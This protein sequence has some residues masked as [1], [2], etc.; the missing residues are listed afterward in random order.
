MLVVGAP[1]YSLLE[2]HWP[3]REPKTVGVLV[4]DPKSGDSALRLVED[5]SGLV[6]DED[7]E[8]V[9]ALEADLRREV[10]DK[11][12]EAVLEE[13]E[14]SLSNVL[15]LGARAAARSGPLEHTL[16]RLFYRHAEPSL[17]V[18]SLRAAAGGFGR[19][20]DVETEGWAPA[21][22]HLAARDDLFVAHV[23]GDS[24]EPDIPS[25]SLCVFRK[26]GGGTRQGKILLVEM[27]GTS[28]GGGAVTIKRYRSRKSQSDEGW[29]HEQIIMEPLNPKYEPWLLDPDES[30]RVIGE[31]VQVL[32][33]QP[34]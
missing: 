32:R 16:E 33:Q 27:E 31:F 12:G 20:E 28:R 22:P 1:F 9:E 14:G 8:V 3:G 17:P 5:W 13:L 2:L 23:E 4:V 10:R 18:W 11:G 24:M 15:R 26:P 34:V 6:D 30:F 7:L 29:S 25:G 19:D 21:P